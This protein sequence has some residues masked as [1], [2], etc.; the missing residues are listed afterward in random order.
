MAVN[1]AFVTD[2]A[3]G[4]AQD[5]ADVTQDVMQEAGVTAV[6]QIGATGEF[7]S[8]TVMPIMGVVG[9]LADIDDTVF[10]D[11]P[12]GL[13]HDHSRFFPGARYSKGYDNEAPKGLS[14]PTVAAK[15]RRKRAKK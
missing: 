7:P 2:A 5:P 8:S 14:V 13:I 3:G 4:P 12:D 10:A 11:P 1:K 9:A 15:P 6:V